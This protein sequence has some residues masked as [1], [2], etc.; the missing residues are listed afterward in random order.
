MYWRLAGQS[1]R[2][3]HFHPLA[4]DLIVIKTGADLRAHRAERRKFAPST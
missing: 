3:V 4:R 2:A 1:P